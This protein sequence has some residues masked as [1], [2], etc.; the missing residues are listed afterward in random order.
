M[1]SQ[2]KVLRWIR[3]SIRA[4]SAYH[5]PPAQDL[6]KLDAMENPYVWP[7][8]MK[9][10]WLQRMQGACLNRYPDPS[11]QGLKTQVRH[12]FQ[13][14]E[15]M[16]IMLGNGSDEL[17]QT[18]CLAAGGQGRKLV[19]V[20]PGFVM[21]RIIATIAAM[22]YVP[23]DLKE[24]FELDL[25]RFLVAVQQHDPAL[26]FIAY[27][28]NPTGNRF[29]EAAILQIIEASNGL[30][31]VDEAYF[32]FCGHSFM[33][34]LQGYP[35][36]LVMGTVSKLGLAGLRLGFLAGNPV[37]MQELEKI[38]L[39]YNINAL[40][41]LSAEF[42][43]EHKSVLDGQTQQIVRDREQLFKQLQSMDGIECF[44]SS[45]NFLLFRTQQ[46]EAQQVF[47]R[48]LDRGVLIKNL[49]AAGPLLSQCLRVTVGTEAENQQFISALQASL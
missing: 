15:G 47:E 2:E 8:E 37:C 12:A 1:D 41:Q 28:N 32:A 42:A 40:T 49:S 23:V 33:R 43:L 7:E 5:V 44:P 29:D 11:A 46:A 39:P 31:V 35:N 24:N 26:I 48:L 36:L 25:P 19:S 13:V 30:V 27:P 38:R 20:E 3:P 34:H 17:I 10:Q 14:P 9:Q 18:L 16:D 4:L 21:Y 22:E 6:I 45:A